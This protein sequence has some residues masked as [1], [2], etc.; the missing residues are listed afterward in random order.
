MLS[1]VKCSQSAPTVLRTNSIDPHRVPTGVPRRAGWESAA[2]HARTRTCRRICPT[3][4]RGNASSAASYA[5]VELGP[6]LAHC[7]HQGGV[8]PT[9]RDRPCGRRGAGTLDCSR[10][11]TGGIAGWLLP[12]IRCPERDP[13]RAGA[14]HHTP[15]MS[16]FT[17]HG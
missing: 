16:A 10:W 17:L 1:A 8:R 15:E 2:E 9:L 4:R 13:R 12:G 14:L 7:A 3:I 6:D 11:D 5:A